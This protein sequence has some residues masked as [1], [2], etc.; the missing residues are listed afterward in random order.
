MLL[1]SL[2]FLLFGSV[3]FSFAQTRLRVSMNPVAYFLVLVVLLLELKDKLLARDEIEAARQVQLA[4]LPKEQPR[5][6]GWSL[7]CFTRSANDV[8]GDLVDHVPMVGGSLGIALGDVAGKGLGAAL[9]CAKLQAS[10]RA[11]LPEYR[12]MVD[13]GGRLNKILQRDG[14]ENRYATLF[15]AEIFPD[16][17]R[18]RVLNAG[19][20]AAIVLRRDGPAR[21]HASAPPLGMFPDTAYREDALDLA[22]GDMV[23]AFSDGLTE[24][25]NED[26]EEFGEARLETLVSSLRGGASADVGARVVAE[27]ERI[28]GDRRPLD[29]LSLFVVARLPA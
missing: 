10:I 16:S 28:L 2:F 24:A 22:A 4:L 8:G 17:G 1:A 12:T 18:M 27:V 25:Q 21:L 11:V 7:W 5:L 29:D 23:V 13:L 14:I 19:H 15:F 3:D 6:P 9:L 26:D 20:N